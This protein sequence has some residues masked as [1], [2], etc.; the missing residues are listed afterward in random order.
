MTKYWW[1]GLSVTLM[2]VL[3]AVGVHFGIGAETALGSP[4]I[5]EPTG[6]LAAF[7]FIGDSIGF[8]WNSVTFQLT[9]IPVFLN[10]LIAIPA[11]MAVFIVISLVRGTE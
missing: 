4:D 6:I 7:D 8:I 10:A 5:E 11:Y 1:L 3:T 2:V 9:D